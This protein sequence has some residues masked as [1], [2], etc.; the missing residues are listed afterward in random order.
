MYSEITRSIKVTV[1]PF[2]LEDQSSP[3]E[4]RY[5]WAYHVRIENGGGCPCVHLVG[6]GRVGLHV[7][8]VGHRGEMHHGVAAA[9]A[10]LEGGDV[11]AVAPDVL[12]RAPRVV[13]GLDAV[14]VH[15]H[16]SALCKRVDHV[17]PDEPRASCDEDSQAHKRF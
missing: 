5:V 15:G 7:V 17:R 8:H 4:D 14:E 12:H 9:H 1:K 11:C 6:A 3:A 13:R 10:A 2:Y 16:V